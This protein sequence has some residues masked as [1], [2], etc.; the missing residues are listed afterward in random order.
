MTL[1]TAPEAAAAPDTG[2]AAVDL[3]GVV[4]R[5][6]AV[7][8]VDGISLRIR[9]GEVV[10]LLGPN[11]AGKTTTV[12]MLLGLARPDRG[13]V[14]VY[15]RPPAEAVGLGLVSA[16]MQ[17][18]GLLKDYTVAETVRLTAVLF[19]KPRTAAGEALRRAG[20]TDVAK[21]LVG[22]C[23]GGQQQRL[24]FAMA[25]LPDPELLI[26]DEPTTGMD[27]AGRHEFWT[28]IRDDA[29]RGRTVIF[30]THYLEE[31]DAYADRVVFVRRGRIV[32][33]GTAAEV[34]AL[35]A[36]RTVRATLPGARQEEL[37]AIGGVDRAEVR[38][39]TVHLHGNDTD[40]IARHLLTHTTARD[41]EITSRNLEDAF[42]A[43]TADE[44]TPR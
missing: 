36:G 10:A 23:S 19:G 38:G 42:L 18:G 22:K 20:L 27:V 28:A 15:G 44:E 24:R 13:T 6:G 21:R 16:V 31:A 17:S 32:A 41:L 8:A 7:T 12:D 26:L 40:R 2:T 1:T 33:D 43:L 30:A 35:A 25:L 39:D 9:P 34:K 14:A 37:A 5:F 29:A 3:D 4:K 11:G